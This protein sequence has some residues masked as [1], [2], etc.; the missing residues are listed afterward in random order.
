ML[1]NSVTAAIGVLTGRGTGM[2][3]GRRKYRNKMGQKTR[4]WEGEGVVGREK[5]ENHNHIISMDIYIHI[6]VCV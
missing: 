4:K 5:G 2:G 1:L 6:Y 3:G